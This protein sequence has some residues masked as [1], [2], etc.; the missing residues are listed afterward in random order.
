LP[1]EII[2]ELMQ[3]LLRPHA[4]RTQAGAFWRDWHLVAVDGTQFSLTNTAQ[5]RALRPKAR[6]R[7][8]RAA[9]AKM[10]VVVLL[11]LGLHNPLAAAIGRVR[12][13]EWGWPRSC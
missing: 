12:E 1:W 5:V 4:T 3:R 2:T 13:S 11:E 6:S 8:G 10:R 7:Q 9:F